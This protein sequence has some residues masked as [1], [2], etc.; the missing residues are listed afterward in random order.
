M[1]FS[2]PFDP[3]NRPKF[4]TTL[5]GAPDALLE[6]LKSPKFEQSGFRPQK[7]ADLNISKGFFDGLFK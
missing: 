3:K 1:D 5:D 4:D 6:T 2:D 7:S